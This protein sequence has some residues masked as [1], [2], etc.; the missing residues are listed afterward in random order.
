LHGYALLSG[1]RTFPLEGF[2]PYRS[3]IDLPLPV[4]KH[5]L[6]QAQTIYRESFNRAWKTYMA[7][8]RHEEI[9][10]RVAWAAV[11]KSYRKRSD[12]WVPKQEAADLRH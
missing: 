10:H 6:S 9:A 12:V 11:K 7:D 3:N 4:Q 1:G 8:P 2:M 5:Q